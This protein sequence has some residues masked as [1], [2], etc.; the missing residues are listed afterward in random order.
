MRLAAL[1]ALLRGDNQRH[2]RHAGVLRAVRV[3]RL[4][5]ITA[6]PRAGQG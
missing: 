1:V 4:S 6:D 3:A 5:D 2:G